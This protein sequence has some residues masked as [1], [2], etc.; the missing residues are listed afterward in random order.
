MWRATPQWQFG[1]VYQSKT[2][3][4]Y[5][6]GE[7]VLNTSGLGGAPFPQAVTYGTAAVE[8]FTWPEQYGAGVQWRATEKVMLALDI[9]QYMWSDA[10]E[11][12][13]VNATDP[14]TP[15]FPSPAPLPPFVF[16]WEDQTVYALGA[17]WRV[18]APITLRAGYNHGDSPVPGRNAKARSFQPPPKTMRR[19]AWAGRPAKATRSTLQSSAPSRTL[20]PI[21]PQ[22]P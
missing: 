4:D 15:G 17:E 8:G 1:F 2:E 18:S 11:L 19:L 10:M 9:K 13:T 21:R 14:N 16:Q 6:D 12:I 5:D 3:G 7:L 20:R 22:I